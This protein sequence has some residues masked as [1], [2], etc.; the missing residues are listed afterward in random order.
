MW[1]FLPIVVA[2]LVLLPFLTRAKNRR[3][4]RLAWQVYLL[5]VAGWL[6]YLGDRWEISGL[7]ADY[8]GYGLAAFGALGFLGVNIWIGGPLDPRRDPPEDSNG[9]QT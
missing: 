4:E 1:D 2:F 5:S 3:Q 7:R 9:D 6:I 8:V